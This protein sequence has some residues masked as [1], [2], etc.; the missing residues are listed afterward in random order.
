[1]KL[2]CTGSLDFINYGIELNSAVEGVD[3]GQR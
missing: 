1:M 3:Q 2:Q